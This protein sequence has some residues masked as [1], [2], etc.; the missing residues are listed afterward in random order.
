M[1]VSGGTLDLTNGPLWLGDGANGTTASFE[2]TGGAV[3][4]H[5][6]DIVLG[7]NLGSVGTWTMDAGT[8]AANTIGQGA[9]EGSTFNFNGGLITL[10]GDQTGLARVPYFLA[11]GGTQFLFDPAT[12]LTT[13]TNDVVPEPTGL[14]L[15]GLVGL[16]AL[17][18]RRTGRAAR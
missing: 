18:R 17:R 11:V 1:I 4:L 12:N 2:Q 13:I 8:L 10:N 5:D 7:R 15:I 9:N 6:G 3:D 14:A 16:V